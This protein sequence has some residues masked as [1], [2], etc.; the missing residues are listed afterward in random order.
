[1]ISMKSDASQPKWRSLTIEKTLITL[2]VDAS[3]G[4]LSE[5]VLELRKT[6][7]ANTIPEP[8]RTSI[9]SLWLRQFKSPLIG[10]LLF[11]GAILLILEHNSDAAVIF[12]V[13]TINSIIGVFHEYRAQQTV[14]ALRNLTPQNAVVRRDGIT[15][16]IPA[17][18]IVRGDILILTEGDRIVADARLIEANHLRVNESLLTGESLP[19][20]KDPHA[21]PASHDSLYTP[22]L[23]YAGT[24][25]THGTATAVVYA[26]GVETKLGGISG[27]VRESRTPIPLETDIAMLSRI[28]LA[29]IAG[30]LLVV[31]GLGLRTSQPISEVLFTATALAVSAIPEGLPVV[32]TIVLSAGMWR[33]A[34]R[35]VLVKKLFA[36]E[37]LG[38]TRVLAVDKTGTITLNQMMVVSIWTPDGSAKVSGEGY[39]PAGSF[40]INETL[41]EPEKTPFIFDLAH[42]I[43]SLTAH[44][45][46]MKHASEG[47]FV[48]GDPTEAALSV[49][50]KKVP[51]LSDP[52]IKQVFLFNYDL[53]YAGVETELSPTESLYTIAGAPEAVLL[54][55]TSIKTGGKA[56]PMSPHERGALAAQLE[57]MA[58]RGLRVVAIASKQARPSSN[59]L[60]KSAHEFTFDAFVGIADAVRPEAYGMIHRAKS[61]GL[62]VVMITGDLPTTARTIGQAVGI[63]EKG[64]HIITGKELHEL[65]DAE[66][67][68]ILPHVSIFARVTPDDKLRIIELY[69]KAHMTIAMTGDGVNDAPSLVKADLGIAMG[70]SGTDVARQASD[71]L[72]LND[73]LES[74]NAAIDEGRAMYQT[75][76]K[77]LVYLFSTNFGE[78]CIIATAFALQ[79]AIPINANQIIWLNLVTDGFL[80]IGLA[81]E[82]KDPNDAIPKLKRTKYIL[83]RSDFIGIVITGF[84]MTTGT[85]FM[86]LRY[87]NETTVFRQT[88]VLITMAMFQWVH[89]WAIRTDRRSF[90]QTSVL[91]NPY[92]VGATF[93]I[94]V[95]QLCAV[96][97]PT[98]QK[99]L[100]TT[101]V[102]VH[103]WGEALLVALSLLVVEEIRKFYRRSRR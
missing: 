69:Q 29:V 103:I 14:R 5:K 27:K 55:C 26:V 58:E 95:L 100:H 67:R 49:F 18:E 86:Y 28:V 80:D 32:L 7:G 68:A 73:N 44:V 30:L 43:N 56:V 48:S 33:M 93:I 46:I 25:I 51:Q 91:R 57:T 97:T 76:R 2:G 64:D 90:F 41:V 62:R 12:L 77:V 38:Q 75:L 21:K 54:A 6:Y 50:A 36:V 79:L 40:F 94:I 71:I 84:I 9:F 60:D 88:A 47:Y 101:V 19:T 74:I 16:T 37:A 96:Y 4:I 78:I 17:S 98:L 72:L 66:L 10:V 89:A 34:K 70:R 13:L 52:K 59:D 82:P 99:I 45:K 42:K 20:T 65:P 31:I 83:H 1:M 102:P 61:A 63:F 24:S 3:I 81:L 8:P 87:E 85:M 92:L 53:K 22:T 23:I 11:A 35:N 15:K 39:A